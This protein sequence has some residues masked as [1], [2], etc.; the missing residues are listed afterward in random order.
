MEW[1]TCVHLPYVLGG[2]FV[3]TL[4][5]LSPLTHRNSSKAFIPLSFFMVTYHLTLRFSL[6]YDD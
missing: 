2:W 6:F 3:A 4:E 5:S 1:E